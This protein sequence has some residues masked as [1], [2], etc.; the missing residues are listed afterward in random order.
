MKTRT[1]LTLTTAGLLLGASA[2]VASAVAYGPGGC[3]RDGP[4]AMRGAAMG[5]AGAV[6]PRSAAGPRVVAM[7][8]ADGD[9]RVTVEEMRTPIQARLTRLDRD[10]D[11]AV[12]AADRGAPG[13]GRGGAAGWA[14]G[15]N[16]GPGG[17][18]MGQGRGAPQR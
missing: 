18:A 5:P 4:A 7:L 13:A 6:G 10:G 2:L 11:G 1:L 9:G 12:S 15:G 17:C 3:W 14:R 8:D 16:A